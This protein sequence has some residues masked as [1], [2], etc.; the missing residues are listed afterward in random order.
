MFSAFCTNFLSHIKNQVLNATSPKSFLTRKGRPALF[1]EPCR[2]SSSSAIGGTAGERPW[3]DESMGPGG[4]S[5]PAFAILWL[6]VWKGVLSA[7]AVFGFSP[8]FSKPK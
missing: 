2:D 1:S 3:A 4:K 6:H 8:K 5:P 7:S